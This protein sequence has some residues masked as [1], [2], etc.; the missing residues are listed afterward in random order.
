MQAGRMRD[1]VTIVNFTTVRSPSGQPVQQWVDGMTV[2]AEVKGIS[3]RELMASGAM[4]AE[5]TI[6][7]WL[8]FR[9]DITSS[10]RLRVLSGPFK[11]MTLSIA[12]T[13]IADNKG[14]RLEIL[15]NQ[16]VEQ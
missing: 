10:S 11:G 9:R 13:P 4:K 3:G 6:R 7:I 8:R 2:W 12:G 5:A 14:T 15:C 16:G 1:R